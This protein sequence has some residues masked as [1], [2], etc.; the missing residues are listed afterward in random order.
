MKKRISLCIA[1]AVSLAALACGTDREPDATAPDSPAPASPS[2][3]PST[4]GSAS[5]QAQPSQDAPIPLEEMR[6]F[7]CDTSSVTKDTGLVRL[8]ESGDTLVLRPSGAP[9]ANHLVYVARSS[10]HVLSTTPGM[11]ILVDAKLVGKNLVLCWSNERHAQAPGGGANDRTS[12]GVQIE[13]AMHDIT[14]AWSP[15]AAIVVPDAD[16][17]AWMGTILP[18]PSSP[19]RFSIRWF[20]DSMFQ[21][22]NLTAANRPAEDGIFDSA[23]S[24][25]DAKLVTSGTPTRVPGN[26]FVATEL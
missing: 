6:Q 24:I 25:S 1:T 16:Y 3:P 20:R 21:F 8:G 4:G 14:G 5:A 19:T 15:S 11:I 18:D 9:C 13:C 23:V 10:E 22:L 17:A 7:A 26:A 12:L 2:A